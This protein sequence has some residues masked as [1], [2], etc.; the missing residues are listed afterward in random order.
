MPRGLRE[1]VQTCVTTR[2]K[3]LTAFDLFAS[4]FRRENNFSY[5]CGGLNLVAPSSI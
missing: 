2:H 4:T 3:W 1:T 5:M